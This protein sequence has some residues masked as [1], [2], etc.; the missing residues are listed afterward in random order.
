MALMGWASPDKEEIL[1]KEKMIESFDLSRINKAPAVFDI[2]KLTWMNGEYLRQLSPEELDKRLRP[3]Y[4]K[5]GWKA[6][7][8]YY[9]AVAGAMQE[10]LKLLTDMN[11]HGA[12]FFNPV[13]DYEEKG[14]KKHFRKEGAI[15]RLTDLYHAFGAITDWTEENL[16]NAVRDLAEKR[17]E[18]AGKLIHP[19]RLATSGLTY[20][21]SAF[22]I[23][24]ILGKEEV[25]ERFVKA[26]EYIEKLED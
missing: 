18:G 19:M 16:E 5:W 13:D 17:G 1:S 11:P 8:D 21:P 10:R 12:F 23:V 6:E 24:L 4:D 20:G 26:W 15:E 3:F 22:E 25:L 7:D 9:V 14:V 2:E